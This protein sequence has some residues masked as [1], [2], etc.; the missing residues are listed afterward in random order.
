MSAP[1]STLYIYARKS[2]EN[3][4]KQ[5]ESIP[6]QIDIAHELALR[7]GVT[8][9]E[10][11]VL[12]EERT[13]KKPGRPVFNQLMQV[14]EKNHHTTVYCWIFNRL[15]RN[16][17]DDGWIRHNIE[18]GKLTIIT[19]TAKFDE[20][21]N[22][23]VTA[24]EGA[25][26]TQYS[27]DLGKMIKDS[28]RSRRKKGIYPGQ[29]LPGYTWAGPEG[30]MYHSPDGK[31]FSLMQQALQLILHGTQP[32]EALRIL[33]EDWG[34]R[35]NKRKKLGGGPIAHSTWFE[36]LRNP[37]YCGQ[38]ISHR[39][40][41]L[42]KW[43]EGTHQQMISRE[44]FWQLQEIL[45]EQGRPRP[46]LPAEE[47]LLGLFKCGKCGR[48]ITRD[49]HI[50][51]RCLCKHKY[52]AKHQDTCPRCGLHKSK[53]PVKRRH[54]HHYLI[55]AGI[56]KVKKGESKCPEPASK[57]D[58]IENQI[59]GKLEQITIP[60]EFIDW[61]FETL[62]EQPGDE[63]KTEQG[64]QEFLQT[65]VAET[66][67]R[68]E[69]LKELYKKGVYEYEGGEQKFEEER[70]KE[71]ATIKGFK[72]NLAER[73]G[74]E[75]MDEKEQEVYSFAKNALGWFR[76]GGFRTKGQILRTLSAEGVILNK[77]L[78]LDLD[79]VFVE[80]KNT[81]DQVRSILPSFEPAN[82]G[83]FC[84]VDGNQAMVSAIKSTWL[85]TWVSHQKRD[86]KGGF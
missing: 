46:S 77:T 79:A 14:V 73:M 38:F 83:E 40:T 57:R 23:I 22:A 76:A 48:S 62:D 8:I 19:S 81:L 39:N 63:L 80:I 49:E 53:V 21:T 20:S 2:T 3:D 85:A 4:E 67:K 56:K 86:T 25:Q 26:G 30:Q 18:I 58:D 43:Y 72:Q 32:T 60:Q 34:F 13:G 37:Y 1:I 10:P 64:I 59:V 24:V 55:C 51:V 82:F 68:L 84:L 5:V 6:R 42:E 28:N 31:R 35:T 9:P 47:S 12:T 45:G 41:P 7:D 61:G 71:L 36:L 50:Q 78:E 33:N 27:R 65:S 66:Q 11:H 74:G 17:K 54:E 29:P 70:Q 16:S 15:S 44:E 52:S 69:R 75:V